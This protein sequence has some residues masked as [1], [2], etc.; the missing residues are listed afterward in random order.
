MYTAEGKLIGVSKGRGRRASVPPAAPQVINQ[1]DE[2]AT[3]L[4]P[5]AE[6]ADIPKSHEPETPL[7]F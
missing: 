4:E 3:V 6:P 2:A 7:Y 5:A 1:A